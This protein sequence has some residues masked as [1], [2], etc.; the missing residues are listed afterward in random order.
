MGDPFFPREPEAELDLEAERLRRIKK[1]LPT[2][3]YDWL[4]MYVVDR[5]PEDF[6]NQLD[7]AGYVLVAKDRIKTLNAKQRYDFNL[8]RLMRDFAEFLERE[9]RYV[10]RLALA[11]IED[12]MLEHVRDAQLNSMER[13]LS[14]SFDVILPAKDIT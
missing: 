10:V 5:R 9:K 8:V 7:R 6:V 1:S 4:R 11:E 2:K 12:K 14:L 3:L 13:E